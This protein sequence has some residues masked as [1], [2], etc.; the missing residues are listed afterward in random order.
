MK[1]YAKSDD[2]KVFDIL[3]KKGFRVGEQDDPLVRNM[4]KKHKNDVKKAAAEIEKKYSNRFESVE[5]EEAHMVKH[6]DGNYVMT[7][8]GEKVK[9]V[10]F[11]KSK[12]KRFSKSVAKRIA[13]TPRFRL[14]FQPDG[15][16]KKTPIKGTK[17]GRVVREE[18]LE[19][20]EL[21]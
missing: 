9:T 19:L 20:D 17:S 13:N 15:S 2:K 10:T 11:D 6:S 16:A 7:T 1:N 4:L 5:V 3:K 21:G 14:N 18:E 8:D 12:A